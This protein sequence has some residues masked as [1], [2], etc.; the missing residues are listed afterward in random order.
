MT[1]GRRRQR[2]GPKDTVERVNVSMG[3]KLL[4]RIDKHA[5]E[6][7]VSR[8][9]LISEV[10]AKILDDRVA[11]K[12]F[13]ETVGPGIERYLSDVDGRWIDDKIEQITTN[14]RNP[15][16]QDLHMRDLLE[17]IRKIDD[18]YTSASLRKFIFDFRMPIPYPIAA[19]PTKGPS[20]S[21]GE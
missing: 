6:R 2:I 5:Q 19:K 14:Q 3:K 7:N 16:L 21:A 12:R 1:K 20:M 10:L 17:Y 9:L 8:S 18:W 13:V 15:D 4:E 11:E